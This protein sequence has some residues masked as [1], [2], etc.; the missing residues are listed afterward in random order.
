MTT[1][2]WREG[3]SRAAASALKQLEYV[4]A[5]PKRPRRSEAEIAAEARLDHAFVTVLSWDGPAP[6]AFG[7]NIGELPVW[8]EVNADWR[9]SG[10]AY[11]RQQTSRRAIRLEVLAV[12]SMAVANLLKTE[13]ETAINGRFNETGADALLNPKRFRNAVEFGDPARWWPVV[14]EAALVQCRHWAPG[15]IDIM[16]RAE[17]AAAVKR[18]SRRRRK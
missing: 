3:Y 15:G 10:L 11:Q 5:T 9:Q 1:V 8:V 2:G 17:H 18:E 6:R 12:P 4:D 14:L 16:T 7:D 13:L